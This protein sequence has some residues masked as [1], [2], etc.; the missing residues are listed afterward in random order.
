MRMKTLQWKIIFG[1]F[2]LLYLC[3]CRV[4]LHAAFPSDMGKK[5]LTALALAYDVSV[6]EDPELTLK[7]MEVSGG[8]FEFTATAVSD[9]Q[10]ALYG[11]YEIGGESREGWVPS[12]VFLTDESF[13]HVYA[14]VRAGMDIYNNSTLS[15]RQDTIKKYSGII[16]LGKRNDGVQVIYEKKKGYGMGWLSAGDYEN[17][18]VYDGRDKQVLSNGT[19]IFTSLDTLLDP[20]PF[21]LQ[22]EYVARKTYRIMDTSKKMYLKIERT[23][24]EEDSSKKDSPEWMEKGVWHIIK[25]FIN[26]SYRDRVKQWEKE[27]KEAAR[28]QKKLQEKISRGQVCEDTENKARYALTWTDDKEEAG[29][30]YVNR[31]GDYFSVSWEDLPLFCGRGINETGKQVFILS[32]QDAEGGSEEAALEENYLWKVRAQKPQI[33]TRRP[34]VF[35]QYDPEWC[36]KAY[37]SEGCMGT[38]G[39]GVLATVNAVYALTGQYMDVMDLAAYAVETGLRIVGSGTD[40]RIFEAAADKYGAR[41]GFCYDGKSGDIEKLKKKLKKGDVATVHVIG[42]YVAITAYDEKKDRYLLLDSNC[43]PKRETT[44][45]GDWVSP[46][47]LMDGYLYGQMYFFYKLSEE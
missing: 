29:H 16:A 3:S 38:A 47:R 39:C 36:G 2:S 24:M 5:P 30:F 7:K 41:Y 33:Q 18:L 15:Q 20:S 26:S 21:T 27:Q 23:S 13:K 42:H 19:Y 22:L 9:D 17:K 43:L 25:Q 45:F 12:S 34:M 10:K 1:L 4:T 28:E 40:D 31:R 8:R 37:G 44:A 46:A 35:T 11:S 32:M 14:T 6:Y